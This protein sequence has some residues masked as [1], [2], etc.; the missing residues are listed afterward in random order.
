M[1][2]MHICQQMNIKAFQND[3]ALHLYRTGWIKEI[4][5]GDEVYIYIKGQKKN[6]KPYKLII[7]EV[8]EYRVCEGFEEFRDEVKA[9]KRKFH[10]HHLFI[11]YYLIPIKGDH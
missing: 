10:P 3:E 2:T 9:Y 11:I 4:Y 5:E 6:M 1:K 7:V 8:S